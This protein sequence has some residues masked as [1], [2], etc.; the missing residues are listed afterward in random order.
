M[1]IHDAEHSSQAQDLLT[2]ISQLQVK[3]ITAGARPN[4]TKNLSMLF[5]SHSTVIILWMTQSNF[6]DFERRLLEDKKFPLST[7]QSRFVIIESQAEGCS[8]Q[9]QIQYR[10]KF[11][12]NDELDVFLNFLR[13]D[14]TRE[15][16]NTWSALPQPMTDTK[17]TTQALNR[18]YSRMDS[19]IHSDFENEVESN[20][21][22]Y[23]VIEKQSM[24]AVTIAEGHLDAPSPPTTRLWNACAPNQFLLPQFLLPVEDGN[25]AMPYGSTENFNANRRHDD[26]NHFLPPDAMSNFDVEGSVLSEAIMHFNERNNPPSEASKHRLFPFMNGRTGVPPALTGNE[27]PVFYQHDEEMEDEEEGRD[28]DQFPGG[29]DDDRLDVIS[30]GGYSC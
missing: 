12:L 17:I 23:D 2:K 1:I 5:R 7:I 6:T 9:P 21:L 14:V 29:R 20:P 18:H 13:S 19:G 16:R 4:S 30:V 27:T 24:A 15:P 10:T 11:N 28:E 3:H 26:M 22:E 8:I 25:H